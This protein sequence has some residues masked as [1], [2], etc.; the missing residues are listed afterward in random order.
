VGFRITI[1]FLV[2]FLFCHEFSIAYLTVTITI[3][4]SYVTSKEPGKEL[5]ATV[6]PAGQQIKTL[7]NRC[8]AQYN[9]NYIL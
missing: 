2:P 1:P 6:Q 7:D 5:P 4:F 3:I 9:R 8:G